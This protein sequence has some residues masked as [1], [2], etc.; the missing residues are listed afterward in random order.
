MRFF[1]S[2][3]GRIFLTSALLAVLSIGAALYVV[4]R[5]VTEAGEAA[6]QR[7][8]VATGTLVDQ[9][10]TTRTD[11]FMKIARLIAATPKLKPAV[12]ETDSAPVLVVASRSQDLIN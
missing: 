12:Y 3:R 4:N 9:L 8:I 2:L 10:R 6:L 1:S 11:L 7:D 5:R